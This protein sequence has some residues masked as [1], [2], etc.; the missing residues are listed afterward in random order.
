MKTKNLFLLMSSILVVGAFMFSSCKKDETGGGETVTGT[1]KGLVTDESGSPI[2]DVNVTLGSLSA[3]TAA[4]GTYILEKAPVAKSSVLFKKAGFADAS[5]TINESSFKDGIATADAVMEVA[6]ASITGKCIDG[7][8]AALAGV[9]VSL[10][11]A[12]SIQTDQNGT[13]KFENLTIKEYTLTFITSELTIE[14]KVAKEQFS[15]TTGY[16]VDLGDINMSATEILPGLTFAQLQAAAQP[17]YYNEL[18][19][20]RNGDDYPHFDWSTDLFY[21]YVAN[22]HIG[23]LEE[24]NEGTTIQIQNSEE[25]GHWLNP[26]DL[27]NFDSYIFGRKAITE[28]NCKMYLKVRT[29]GGLVKFGVM[30]VDPT[31]ASP[32]A[33]RIGGL[34]EYDNDSYTC[35]YEGDRHDFEFD[36]SAYKGKEIYIA[37]GI[38]RAETGNY[39]HQLVLRRIIF[40]K[41]CPSDWGWCP[42]EEV[43]GLGTNWHMTKEILRSTMPITEIKSF[44][45]ISEV[46]AN[47]DT[48]YEG[49]SVWRSQDHLMGYWAIVP[50]HADP[51]PFPSEGYIIKTNGGGTPVS[52]DE[53]RTYIYAKLPIAAGANKMTM[54]VRGFSTENPTY[55]RVVAITE[56]AEVAN[57]EATE[58]VVG[59]GNEANYLERVSGTYKMISD[60]GGVFTPEEYTKLVFDLSAYNGQNVVIAIATF[61]GED[62]DEENK[63]GIHSLVLE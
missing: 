46:E 36:L 11:G 6:C 2:S 47:R 54:L 40:A 9:N 7:E 27:E 18:R 56:K 60:G 61:K 8:G 3:V 41:E 10:N 12:E 1:V 63:M 29:H 26:A 52:L 50:V 13:F 31:E 5:V 53:P 15:A 62:N 49:Y 25:E 14:K 38:Y 45:G 17:W 42:G 34:C 24:Q 58:T 39:W 30:V 43:T 44:T 51:E 35:G 4:N 48:Y 16:L 19:G 22:A 55:F 33:V 28:D 59:S 20:G 32:K 21:C 23:W 37:I 57:L